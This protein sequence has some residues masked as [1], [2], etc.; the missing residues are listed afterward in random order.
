MSVNYRLVTTK[1]F[2]EAS[3]SSHAT[4]VNIE[5]HLASSL[6]LVQGSDGKEHVEVCH[7]HTLT[8][9][10]GTQHHTQLELITCGEGW[11]GNKLVMLIVDCR[12]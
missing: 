9:I 8:P 12:S 6:L 4:F 1:Y 11:V 10:V 2:Y 7:S 3:I 5:H